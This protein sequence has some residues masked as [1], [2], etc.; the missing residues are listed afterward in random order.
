MSTIRVRMR[1]RCIKICL[2]VSDTVR[3]T[4]HEQLIQTLI[5]CVPEVQEDDYPPQEHRSVPPQLGHT[6][7]LASGLVPMESRNQLRYLLVC[8]LRGRPVCPWVVLT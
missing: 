1:F 2:Y 7:W 8:K 3:A 5:F 6:L 4:A